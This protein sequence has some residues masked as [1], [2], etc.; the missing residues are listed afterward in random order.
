MS[1]K[2]PISL[3]GKRGGSELILEHLFDSDATDTSSS[4][5][6]LNLYNTATVANGFLSLISANSDYGESNEI[7]NIG[8][9][10]MSISVWLKPDALSGAEYPDTIFRIGKTST[11]GNARYDGLHILIYSNKV[12]G[13]FLDYND[14]GLAHNISAASDINTDSLYHAVIVLDAISQTFELY[15]DG[16]SQGSLDV[17]GSFPWDLTSITPSSV[18][19]RD[20]NGVY[21]DFFDGHIDS[22]RVYRK[23]LTSDDV[24]NLYN[25]GCDIK[26]TIVYDSFDS[27]LGTT[28]NNIPN[29]WMRY[30]DPVTRVEFGNTASS[31]GSAAFRGHD[32]T[33]INIP[34]NIV[35]IA[36]DAF[37]FATQ[38]NIALNFSEGLKS[39]GNTSFAQ[40]RYAGNIFIPTTLTSV[41]T[42]AFQ[43]INGDSTI[44]NYHINSP[45]SIF[46]GSSIFQYHTVNDT[47]YVHADYLSQYDA[48]WKT[49]Q[50]FDGTVAEWTSYPDPMP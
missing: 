22:L 50:G 13:G 26:P 7:I 12:F 1:L 17:S 34:S 20:I 44:R 10:S 9:G 49:N 48:T 32:C 36:N 27:V 45:A 38:Q 42:Q 35:S 8:T 43:K 25:E 29:N 39:I 2:F 33:E 31:I 47:I 24:V 37:Y 5:I 14:S 15:V 3:V 28:Y 16:V 21:A 4:G 30:Q 23:A 11:S 18:G 6:D 19:A 41:A 40:S 46:T